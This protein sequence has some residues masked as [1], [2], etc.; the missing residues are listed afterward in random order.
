M[1][2]KT[3]RW[4][5]GGLGHPSAVPSEGTGATAIAPPSRQLETIRAG[6]GESQ[7]QY[8]KVQD[9]RPRFLGGGAG[10]GQWIAAVLECLAEQAQG[11]I[12]ITHSSFSLPQLRIFST[13]DRVELQQEHAT[14]EEEGQ[15]YFTSMARFLSPNLLLQNRTDNAIVWNASIVRPRWVFTDFRAL[16]RN[17]EES[18][19][20]W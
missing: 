6:R 9:P 16:R 15:I 18:T 10:R 1:K 11:G 8:P 7:K 17:S 14:K 12:R 4:T 20:L 2:W 19:V 3:W 5:G 13:L